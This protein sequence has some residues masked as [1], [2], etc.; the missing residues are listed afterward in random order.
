LV[1]VAPELAN[2][3]SLEQ[4]PRSRVETDSSQ[5]GTFETGGTC[6]P[7]R[8]IPM[9]IRVEVAGHEPAEIEFLH[10]S[11]EHPGFDRNVVAILV[12]L[13]ATIDE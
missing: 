9:K 4:N 13:E 11:R 7:F 1:N 2:D 8:N 3:A 5:D 12:P 10:R 6:V